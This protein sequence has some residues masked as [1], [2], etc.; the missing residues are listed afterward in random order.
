MTFECCKKCVVNGCC[1][2]QSNNNCASCNDVFLE[3][4]KKT[5]ELEKKLD[6]AIYFLKKYANVN[7]WQDCRLYDGDDEEYVKD[8][9]YVKQGYEDAQEAF[10]L[11]K[12]VK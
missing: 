2:C 8:A 1:S 12:E 4:I 7:S 11:I 5:D 6:I 10:R 9:C 3:L